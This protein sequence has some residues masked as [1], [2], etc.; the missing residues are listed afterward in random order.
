MSRE[1]DNR[2][3]HQ[4]GVIVGKRRQ[5]PVGLLIAFVK[6]ADYQ[7]GAPRKGNAFWYGLL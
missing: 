2:A 7:R 5:P 1:W 4:G 3:E 6:K